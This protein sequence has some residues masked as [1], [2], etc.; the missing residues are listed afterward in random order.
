MPRW[1]RGEATIERVNA[2]LRQRRDAIKA[3]GWSSTPMGTVPTL[4]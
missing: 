1:K 2:T 4:R 3:S